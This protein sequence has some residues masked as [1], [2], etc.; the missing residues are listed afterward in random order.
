MLCSLLAYCH[1]FTSFLSFTHSVGFVDGL[2]GHGVSVFF[3]LGIRDGVPQ[4]HK[5]RTPLVRAQ[6][7]SK[8]SLSKPIIGQNIGLHA[9]S[10]SGMYVS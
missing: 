7:L 2:T 6:G 3:A 9:V 8:V 1:E 10:A 5:L 4:S